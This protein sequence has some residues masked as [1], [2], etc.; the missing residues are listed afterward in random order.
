MCLELLPVGLSQ[1][2]Y[3]SLPRSLIVFMHPHPHSLLPPTLLCPMP[4]SSSSS[5]LPSH[6]P[7]YLVC[8]C[9]IL[10]ARASAPVPA[11]PSRSGGTLVGPRQP[12]PARILHARRSRLSLVYDGAMTSL[13]PALPKASFTTLAGGVELFVV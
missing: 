2:P 12:R 11:P 1:E 9:C 8:S 3:L 13:R 10:I 7:A 4:I 5:Y 6:K